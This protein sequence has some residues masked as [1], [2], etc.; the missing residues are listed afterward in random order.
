MPIKGNIKTIKEEIRN[1]DILLVAV[2]KT[3]TIEEIKEAI[4]SGINIIGENRIQEAEA[5]FCELRD[6]FKKNN[7]E[8][9][10]IGR[11]Q[12]NKIKKAVEMFD[13]IQ[14]VDSLKI[15][16]EID[17]R[18]KEKNKTQRIFIEVN[19][20][21]EQQKS[22]VIPKG[23]INLVKEI[24]KLKNIKLEGLMCIP[25]YSDNAEDSRKYFRQMKK[26]FDETGL[27]YLSIGM[28]KDYRIAIE[29]G[30]N[31]IRIGQGIFG[32]RIK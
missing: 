15:A 11:L 6:Y 1:S 18:A 25:P 30:S 9:H 19:I 32:E 2:T 16:E 21:N 3:R 20:G 27:K 13:V 17:K 8:F 10:F 29:E 26:L 24:R 28:T 4:D 5:K 7:V 31:M 12:S 22:G 14:T 23:V